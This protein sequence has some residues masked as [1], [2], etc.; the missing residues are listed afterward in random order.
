[1]EPWSSLGDWTDDVVSGGEQMR[2]RQNGKSRGAWHSSAAGVCASE[3]KTK[4]MRR[5]MAE[6]GTQQRWLRDWGKRRNS[7]EGLCTGRQ[8]LKRCTPH[9]SAPAADCSSSPWSPGGGAGSARRGM[10]E[11]WIPCLR[12]WDPLSAAVGVGEEETA[13]KSDG[14]WAPLP[15]QVIAKQ[16]PADVAAVHTLCSECTDLR[17]RPPCPIA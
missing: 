17:Q 5:K 2:L 11:K 7:L 1:M 12:R 6:A 10:M 8:G 9:S 4:R 15:P 13:S 16:V 3:T 14:L